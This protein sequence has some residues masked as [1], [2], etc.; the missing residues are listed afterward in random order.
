MRTSRSIIE[1]HRTPNDDV[2]TGL[3]AARYD[4]LTSLLEIDLDGAWLECPWRNLHEHLIGLVSKHQRRRRE[5][6]HRLLGSHEGGGGE[7]VWFQPH[8]RVLKGN[9]GLDAPRVRIENVADEEYPALK[10]VARIGGEGH[11]DGLTLRH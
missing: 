4:G 5:D 11:V 9:T 2:L 7:H 8:V 10:D 6:H 1:Q 3:E